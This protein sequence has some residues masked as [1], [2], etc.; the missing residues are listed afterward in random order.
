MIALPLL[1]STGGGASENGDVAIETLNAAIESRDGQRLRVEFAQEEQPALLI[2]PDRGAWNWSTTSKLSIPVENPGGEPLT[3]A[4]RIESARG[5]SLRGSVSI[6]SHSTGDLTIS[7]DA[8]LP[9]SMGMIGGPSLKAAGLEPKTVPVTA[10]EGSIDASRVTSVRLGIW[11]PPAPQLL[12]MGPL[13]VGRP[14]AEDRTAYVGIVDEFGQ[15][16][17][18]TWPE[19]VS[20]VGML[21]AKGDAEARMLAAR[22]ANMPTHDRFGGL[23]ENGWFRATGFFRTAR[24]AGRWWLVTPKG[25][26]F[27]SIGM[28]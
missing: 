24:R 7:I 18:G 20:S 14:S 26:P 13:R 10:T 21:R 11:Q 27:F 22:R 17:R 23:E 9:R 3:L 6:A 8:P 15:F 16:R 1:I 5:R 19:K 12:I 2:R 25:N 28:D 4:L